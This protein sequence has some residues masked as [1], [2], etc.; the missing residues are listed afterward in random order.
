MSARRTVL[1]FA[2]LGIL[3]A[4]TTRTDAGERVGPSRQRLT[5]SECEKLVKD[6]AYP[7][8]PPF[9]EDYVFP[10]KLDEAAMEGK[11]KKIKAAYDQLS[12]NIEVALPILVKHSDDERLSYVFEDTG[13]SGVY[14]KA[15]VGD[16]CRRIIEAHVEV[17]RRHAT[18]LDFASVPRCPSFINDHCGGINKW[19]K[20][21]KDR[22]LADLQLEGIEWALRQKKPRLFESK[23]EWA[24]AK[25]ALE[26]MA[27]G[28]RASGKPILVEHHAQFF[29][30]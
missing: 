29:S 8:K 30:K 9:K 13:T 14:A 7:G 11:Q 3:A 1:A 12:D 17:Y 15:S 16:A 21:R 28:I 25:K 24:E 23:R 2:V 6:L 26:K 5:A 20:R 22:T 19:W 4:F 18:R 27:E 10:G